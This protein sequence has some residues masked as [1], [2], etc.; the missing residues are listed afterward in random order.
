MK[1]RSTCR[2]PW[3]GRVI[4]IAGAVILASC[5]ITPLYYGKSGLDPERDPS[6]DLAS[7]LAKA[8]RTGQRV[9]IYASG[10]WCAWSEL[11]S[12]YR[13]TNP[14]FERDLERAFITV[15]VYW[16]PGKKN[17]AFFAD[18]PAFGAAPTFFI[19]EPDGTVLHSQDLSAYERGH[20]FDGP[21]M[22]EAFL[23]WAPRGLR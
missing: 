20:W 2:P 6:A 21:A 8:E 9:L 3:L 1:R 7:A 4:G 11:W 13:Q 16:G 22:E 14:E 5:A 18:Y 10:D 23:R 17:E 15:P 12:E 19:L